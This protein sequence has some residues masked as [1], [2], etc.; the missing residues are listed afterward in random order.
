[1]HSNITLQNLLPPPPYSTRL[2]FYREK[3]SSAHTFFPL[4][5]YKEAYSM[6]ELGT[7]TS[8]P[9]VGVAHFGSKNSDR[10]S[11]LSEEPAVWMK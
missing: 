4:V 8:H 2:R 9:T 1:M 11:S 6:A 3:A 5:D 10:L 7:L